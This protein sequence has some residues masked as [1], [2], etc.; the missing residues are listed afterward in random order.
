MM[1][2]KQALSPHTFGASRRK[3]EKEIVAIIIRGELDIL[4]ESERER[5]R[6]E[7]DRRER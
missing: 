2:T 5:E 1:V 4:T 7:R 3:S 6:R